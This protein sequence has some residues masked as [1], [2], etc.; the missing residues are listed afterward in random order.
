MKKLIS[1]SEIPWLPAILIFLS[2]WIGVYE[3]I[4][5]S[6]IDSPLGDFF[7]TA[8]NVIDSC[9]W[10][11]IPLALGICW[12]T[13]KWIRS[14]RNDRE[15]RFYRL[16]IIVAILFILTFD[17][18]FAFAK[19]VGNFDFKDL[20]VILLI[21][22][23]TVWLDLAL[24]SLAESIQSKETPQENSRLF[25][26]PEIDHSR[27]S[28]K[29]M[30]LADEII[31]GIPM[32]RDK[33][34]SFALGITGDWGMGKTTFLK[35]IESKI[36][37]MVD[38]VFFNPWMIRDSEN[39]TSEFFSAL[40][41]QLAG[42]YSSFA[43]PINE[44]A[45]VLSC[46]ELHPVTK[47]I[48]DN[49]PNK[50]KADL[51]E[52]KESISEKF[53][54]L[55]KP[56]VIFIDDFDR[57]Q[58]SEIF[59]MLRLI[60]NTADL[61]NT[62]Y[63]TAYDQ[64]YVLKVL[65]DC[66]I[67]EPAEYL[68]KIFHL[69]L[70]LP[71]TDDTELWSHFIS[72]LK[73]HDHFTNDFVGSLEK[74]LNNFNQDKDDLLSVLSTFRKIQRFA[75]LYMFNLS[76]LVKTMPHEIYSLDLLWLELLNV[77]D[78]K[79]YDLLFYDTLTLL[80]KEKDTYILRPSILNF[81]ATDSQEPSDRNSYMLEQVWNGYTPMILNHLFGATNRSVSNL[82]IR[83]TENFKKYF[84]FNVSDFSLKAVELDKLIKEGHAEEGIKKLLDDRVYFSSLFF[85][86]SKYK[87]ND[88]SEMEFRNYLEA[89]VSFYLYVSRFNDTY[90][91]NE[92]EYMQQGRLKNARAFGY[93]GD[94]LFEFLNRKTDDA[95]IAVELSFFLSKC[96]L[97]KEYDTMQDV[98]TSPPTDR[99]SVLT[100]GQ[101][102]DLMRKLMK[103]Y[104]QKNPDLTA[105]DIL[106][107]ESKLGKIFGNCCV[108]K[109]ISQYQE[110]DN[111]FQAVFDVVIEHFSQK[112][113]KPTPEEFD[114]A[115]GRMFVLKEERR[116]FENP[117]EEDEYWQYMS[118]QN[119]NRQERYFGSRHTA[120]LPRFRAAATHP[121]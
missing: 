4:H 118:E 74:Y 121:I 46:A 18:P 113:A 105:L 96:Y 64:K 29:M 67:S 95:D 19:I 47:F 110:F 45:A 119:E 24:T 84:R 107:E 31:A 99:R 2:V 73:K 15:T 94:F 97:T 10:I 108:C 56:V 11:T 63:L 106:R 21:I 58:G 120:D 55:K 50:D 71:K 20:F 7:V 86:L 65:S 14:M 75:S 33:K 98:Y 68:E 69:E 116:T 70:H 16:F 60:R 59:E 28:P 53:A 54:T 80:Y 39:L 35:Y 115:R 100:N 103:N 101:I 6:L 34:S 49:L 117:W 88:L 109:T 12:L 8:Y 104:L 5:S 36:E 1:K 43:R 37:D 57:L 25:T 44:Y 79:V 17:N 87:I 48:A 85:H 32:N 30:K 22:T 114:E 66:G 82:S 41:S 112:E 61:A 92:F 62:I 76:F 78:K 23:G 111:Y 52:K 83:F 72:E 90:L 26:S 102:E 42:K 40:S 89:F 81:G 27:L 77:Y 38:V 93:A 91:K 51:L 13:F 3:L 9:H